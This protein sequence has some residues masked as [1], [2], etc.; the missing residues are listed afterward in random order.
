M[1]G[2]CDR[3]KSIDDGYFVVYDRH[4]SRFEVHNSRQR[5]STFALAVP[6]ASLDARVVEL[7]RKTRVENVL[8]APVAEGA[9]V[10]SVSYYLNGNLLKSYTV[11]TDSAVEERSFRWI[12]EYIIKVA[13]F[14]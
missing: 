1:F 13:F 11:C 9:E 4:R 5:G 7:V 8:E 6:Y 14:L 10:G 2:I 3:L 12:L